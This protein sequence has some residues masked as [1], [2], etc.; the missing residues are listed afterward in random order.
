[1]TGVQT[2]RKRT[3]LRN[4]G[5]RALVDNAI[6]HEVQSPLDYY[7]KVVVI[8]RSSGNLFSLTSAVFVVSP[9]RFPFSLGASTTSRAGRVGVAR[10]G[11]PRPCDVCE[12]CED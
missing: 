10:G 3:S 2:A 11:A 7:M 5:V 8:I 12:P 6:S 4:G 9:L 1:M